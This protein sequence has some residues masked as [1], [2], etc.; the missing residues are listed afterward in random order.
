MKS[1]F[2][3]NQAL[4][5][6]SKYTTNSI[7]D[8]SLDKLS[9]IEL[10]DV[11]LDIIDSVKTVRKVSGDLL[12]EPPDNSE[13]RPDPEN[14]I[15]GGIRIVRPR[16]TIVPYTQSEKR[17]LEKIQAKIV[18]HKRYL[19]E[20]FGRDRSLTKTDERILEQG[21]STRNRFYRK[22]TKPIRQRTKSTKNQYA[23]WLRWIKEND[24]GK[25]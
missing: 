7:V 13:V 17:M 8:A 6:Y 18:L 22:A 4:H 15:Y 23:A 20:H 21:Q 9:V 25:K 24:Q 16:P 5:N 2:S 12:L 11:L 1:F 10:Y 3:F 14:W 19:K